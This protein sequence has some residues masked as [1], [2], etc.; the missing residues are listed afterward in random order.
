[1]SKLHTTYL[2]D[3]EDGKPIGVATV[4]SWNKKAVNAFVE[5]VGMTIVEKDEYNRAVR[6][7]GEQEIAKSD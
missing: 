2:V 7:I 1:M 4:P 3:Y 5:V 6:T